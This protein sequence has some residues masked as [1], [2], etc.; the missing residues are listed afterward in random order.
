MLPANLD[1]TATSI[2]P[3]G[4]ISIFGA[5]LAKL[6]ADLSGWTGRQL[7][8]ALD[9]VKATISGIRAPL[10]Y[11]SPNQINAQAPVELS[12]GVQTIV[13]DN[14]AGPS[15]ALSV[16]VVPMAPAIFF[17]PVAA[18]LK[19]AN[20]TL[21]SA[22]NPA[23]AG[24]VLLIYATGLGQTTPAVRTGGLSPAD[25]LARTA[26]VTATIGSQPATVVYS[27]ASPGFAGLYQVAVT[28]PAGV[29]GSVALQISAGAAESNTVTIPVQ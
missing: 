10:I 14:G 20:F 28:V 25:T 16:N 19:N 23:R 5:N 2:A 18:V 22:A 17:Y 21:V 9:A 3:G 4:L 8:V 27:I 24:D 15:V 13:V 1:K 26:S 29:T 6:T 11:V 12:A 7:P